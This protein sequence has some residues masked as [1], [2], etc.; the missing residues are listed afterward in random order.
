[1]SEED[2]QEHLLTQCLTQ[3]LA[4][5]VMGENRRRNRQ[6]K[7]RIV[8]FG[9]IRAQQVREWLQSQ[10]VEVAKVMAVQG[11]HTAVCDSAADLT[12]LLSLDQCQLQV[13]AGAQVIRFVRFNGIMTKNEILDL[14]TE[15]LADEE[16]YSDA[17]RVVQQAKTPPA[18]HHGRAQVRATA[19][20]EEESDEVAENEQWAAQ[21]AAVDSRRSPGQA[22][23]PRGPA[24][25]PQDPQPASHSAGVKEIIQVPPVAPQGQPL[26]QFSAAGSQFNGAGKGGGKNGGKGAKGGNSDKTPWC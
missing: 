1:M 13:G 10:A 20:L 8:G 11:A 3:Q 6:P 22:Q 21:V 9:G 7:A 5:L 15:R 16:V 24:K 14:I 17:K 26:Q 2:K 23:G 25:T 19:T 4:Q 18:T 12:T